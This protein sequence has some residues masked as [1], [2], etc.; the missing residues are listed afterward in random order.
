MPSRLRSAMLA[1]DA[2][3]LPASSLF[4]DGG[5]LSGRRSSL[6]HLLSLVSLLSASSVAS[7][8]RQPPQRLLSDS[9]VPRQS[10]QRL[11]SL[12]SAAPTLTA[13]SRPAFS[14]RLPQPRAPATFGR[15]RI[16]GPPAVTATGLSC[17]SAAALPRRERAP[18]RAHRAAGG[19]ARR[20]GSARTCH[21][22]ARS[23]GGASSGHFES[24]L[25]GQ[26]CLAWGPSQPQG[27]EDS[28]GK[29]KA[30]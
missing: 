5:L 11:L 25:A 14:A 27:L 20:G 26:S 16:T 30:F 23:G 17:C 24:A 13:A 6:E 9:S 4:A 2:P 15:L 28:R 22:G 10:P 29:K 12:L 18:L 21:G 7:A 19:H 1:A 8:P 3:A